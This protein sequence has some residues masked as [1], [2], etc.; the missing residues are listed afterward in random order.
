MSL[1]NLHCPNQSAYKKNH[2]TE[3]LLIRI[4]NDLLVA[5]DEKKGTVLMLLDLSAAFDTVDH[6]LLLKILSDEIGLR[7][8]A[9][10][11]FESFLTGRA[12]RIRL[13]NVTSD[14]ILIKFGVPQGSV[15]GP[16]LFNLYIRSIYGCV[17]DL[18]F[19]ISGYAD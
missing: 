11:W 5:T 15:L 17:K 10:L 16:V 9:L 19:D 18:G 7:G 3:T 4:W 14:E 13:G 1:N 2:S 12:Q 6:K 8:V